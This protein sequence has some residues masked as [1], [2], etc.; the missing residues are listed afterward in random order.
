MKNRLNKRKFPRF[1]CRVPIDSKK[2]TIFDGT[3]TVNISREGIG[4]I[5]DRSIPLSKKIAMEIELNPGSEPLLV[6]AQVKWVRKVAGKKRYQVGLIFSD[7]ISG[8][9][10]RL[11]AYI[12]SSRE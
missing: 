11:N 2:G 3:Q 7:V 8:S 5:A 6:I 9:K 1:G 12:K 10:S 4:F